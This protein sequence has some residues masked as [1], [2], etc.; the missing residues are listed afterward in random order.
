MRESGHVYDLAFSP[1]SQFL[2]VSL[3]DPTTRENL[4]V[5][6]WNIDKETLETTYTDYNGIRAILAYSSD[7]ALRVADVYEDKVVMWNAS[8]GEK[9]DTI[10]YQGKGRTEQCI[11]TDGQ[12]FA[13]LTIRDIRVWHAGTPTIVV[14][15]TVPNHVPDS[16]F[17]YQSG[18]MLICKYWNEGVVFSDIVQKQVIPPPIPPECRGKRCAMSPCEELLALIGES[19]QT[20]EVWNITSGTRIAELI[21]HQS[22]I[23][24]VVF[25]SSGEHLISGDIDGK[26][27]VWRVHRWEKQQSFIGHAH[28]FRRA[29][30]HPERKAIRDY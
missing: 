28:P 3:Q 7:G 20:L 26:F 15:L 29:A 5:Q 30:F 23:T 11:S 25:S 24:T 27:V 2:A 9:L 21:E 18:K 6:V 16:L 4:A 1:C 10:E 13:I 22:S 12:Q 14:P 17:F 8:Q 19:G